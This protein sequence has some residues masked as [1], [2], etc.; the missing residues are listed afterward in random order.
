[1]RK[2]RDTITV[3]AMAAA[4][5][6]VGAAPAHAVGATDVP[7]IQAVVW[8]A[9]TNEPVTS[10]LTATLKTPAGGQRTG[11]GIGDRFVFNNLAPG[12]YRM[13]V[14]ANGVR[15]LAD[16]AGPGVTI[17]VDPGPT[18][19][20]AGDFV[21]YGLSFGIT[22]WPPGPCHHGVFAVPGALGTVRDSRTGG[23]V[24]R[25]HCAFTDR[26]GQNEGPCMTT[27]SGFDQTNLSPQ[28]WNFAVSGAG[29]PGVSTVKV[30][31]P[32]VPL[33]KIGTVTQGIVLG[34]GLTA[35]ISG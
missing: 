27:S 4:A 13:M 9:C 11:H 7:T 26:T 19:V 3:V 32:P 30:Q 5:L 17:T 33:Q 22:L 24:S 18:A 23:F 16:S 10:G 2:V 14:S 6:G 1:M 25:L 21:N 8:N 34:I 28:T 15:P 12:T 20:P 29:H 31:V 35:T